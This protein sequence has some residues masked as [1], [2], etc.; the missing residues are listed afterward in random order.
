MESFKP[1]AKTKSFFFWQQLE[2][3]IIVVF[4]SEGNRVNLVKRFDQTFV[5]YFLSLQNKTRPTVECVFLCVYFW[6][7]RSV[8]LRDFQLTNKSIWL[9]VKVDETQSSISHKSIC[10]NSKWCWREPTERLSTGGKHT[11]AQSEN[12]AP[13]YQKE[14]LFMLKI[15]HLRSWNDLRF[16][17]SIFRI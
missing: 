7:K 12:T 17:E 10:R 5:F 11:I 16:K 6:A 14:F 8:R 9:C 15:F 4:D 1:H 13:Q 3:T 2:Y